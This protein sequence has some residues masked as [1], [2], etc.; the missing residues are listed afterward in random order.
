M[1][2]LS[3]TTGEARLLEITGIVDTEGILIEGTRIETSQ[4][5]VV[6]DGTKD[7]T[8]TAAGAAPVLAGTLSIRLWKPLFARLKPFIFLP[9]PRFFVKF[10]KKCEIFPKNL[11]FLQNY[12]MYPKLFPFHF[13]S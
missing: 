9:Q 5:T 3:G 12:E 8:I 10:R 11:K 2:V 1:G 7:Y 6:T 13:Y 4:S